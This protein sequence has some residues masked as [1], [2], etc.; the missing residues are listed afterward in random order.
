MGNPS[1]KAG[2]IFLM[3]RALSKVP[4]VYAHSSVRYSQMISFL[5]SG[6][7]PLSPKPF[8]FKSVL[9]AHNETLRLIYPAGTLFKSQDFQDLLLSW[10][11]QD[12]PV[13]MA[14][15][16]RDLESNDFEVLNK[17]FLRMTL[18]LRILS[19]KPQYTLAPHKDSADTI[20]AF[21]LQLN[22]E[23]PF[24]SY[25]LRD[26]KVFKMVEKPNLDDVNQTSRAVAAFLKSFYGAETSFQLSENQFGISKYVF[27]DERGSAWT[28]H[29][30]IS[31]VG[32]LIRFDVHPL[33]CSHDNLVAIHNPLKDLFFKGSRCDFIRDFGSHGFAPTSFKERNVLLMDLLGGF[34]REDA[35]PLPQGHDPETEFLLR[36]SGK[37]SLELL[38]LSGF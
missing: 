38:N 3:L 8:G 11:R 6:I 36:F 30:E 15:L 2:G 37:T 32:K 17:N 23:N 13:I 4:I 35:V 20:F 31:E 18:R 24:T 28:F 25:F 33:K 26:N 1:A 34:S 14:S 12:L 19:D 27:W 9:D 7:K 21:L 22:E 10:V 16:R 5:N 29:K